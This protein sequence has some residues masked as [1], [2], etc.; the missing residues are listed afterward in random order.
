[1]PRFELP[2]PTSRTPLRARSW[3]GL[4]RLWG[5][6][7]R[8]LR[9][10]FESESQF[11]IRDARFGIF[12]APDR[13]VPQS[14][15]STELSPRLPNERAGNRANDVRDESLCSRFP[16]FMGWDKD[17][18]R[19][20]VPSYRPGMGFVVEWMEEEAVAGSKSEHRVCEVIRGRR[21]YTD[22]PVACDH[23]TV[24]A[25]NSPTS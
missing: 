10:C 5:W 1:T 14:A 7:L 21:F 6:R 9:C 11:P 24:E 2:S 18:T 17:A 8:V 20:G 13:R 15:H 4:T 12:R 19:G 16:F 22:W 25:T 3:P 23:S